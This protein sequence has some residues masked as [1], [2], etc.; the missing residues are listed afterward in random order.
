[1]KFG[2]GLDGEKNGNLENR[3]KLSRQNA[4]TGMRNW[5]FIP[6]A[7]DKLFHKMEVYF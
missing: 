2:V 5:K 7:L 6:G 3:E 4:S 1:M